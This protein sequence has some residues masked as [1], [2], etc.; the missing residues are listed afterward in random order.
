MEGASKTRPTE[1]KV[2]SGAAVGA[3]F[4]GLTDGLANK[5]GVTDVGD[6]T[7]VMAITTGLVHSP[8]ALAPRSQPPR[9]IL[10]SIIPSE[11]QVDFYLAAP[12]TVT[13]VS[14]KEAI[15]LAGRTLTPVAPAW[16]PARRDPLLPVGEK[17]RRQKLKQLRRRAAGWA[18]EVR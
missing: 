6:G 7:T 3:V 11:A 14:E 4:G 13:K 16:L 12:I 2:T 9:L 15:R 10:A 18:T 5:S 17:M 1:T 8:K